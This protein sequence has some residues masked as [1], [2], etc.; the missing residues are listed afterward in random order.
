MG[1]GLSGSRSEIKSE[2]VVV[3]TAC[4]NEHTLTSVV[5]KEPAS[6]LGPVIGSFATV[7]ACGKDPRTPPKD[8]ADN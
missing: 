3:H 1:W 8:N 4:H 2:E 5:S 6:F 7:C